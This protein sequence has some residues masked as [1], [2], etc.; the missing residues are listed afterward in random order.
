ML[1][2]VGLRSVGFIKLIDVVAGVW[3]QR[4]AVSTG[5]N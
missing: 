3:R 5:L 1:T 4:L 2:V